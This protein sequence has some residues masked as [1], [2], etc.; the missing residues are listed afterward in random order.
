MGVLRSTT[1]HAGHQYNGVT[2]GEPTLDDDG[3]YRWDDPRIPDGEITS[4]E[5]L[6]ITPDEP[7]TP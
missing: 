2:L 6:T 7:G 5:P 3:V 1:N 4:V